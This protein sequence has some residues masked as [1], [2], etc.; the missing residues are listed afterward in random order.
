[1]MEEMRPLDFQASTVCDQRMERVETKAYTV[2][3]LTMTDKTEQ[4]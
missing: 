1:M 2:C 4:D 3:A